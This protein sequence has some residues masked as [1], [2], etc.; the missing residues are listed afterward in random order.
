MYTTI[1]WGQDPPPSVTAAR[2]PGSPGEDGFGPLGPAL[3]G[4]VRRARG[5][6]VSRGAD[7]THHPARRGLLGWLADR[8][9]SCGTGDPFHAVLRI[10]SAAG[11][12]RP[13]PRAPHA[14]PAD[15]VVTPCRF[16]DT[17]HGGE[18]LVPAGRR[19]GGTRTGRA[20]KCG[21]AVP[22]AAASATAKAGGVHGRR[23]RGAVRIAAAKGATAVAA[24]ASR[25][26]QA[27]GR[28]HAGDPRGHR[29]LGVR[30]RARGRGAA[31]RRRPAFGQRSRRARLIAL[32]GREPP[33]LPVDA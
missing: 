23:D 1:P 19:G 25:A 26:P 3:A 33:G 32:H 31:G 20:T 12:R 22:E 15:L 21:S 2:S 16:G 9:P 7:A 30:S 11:P 5:R 24:A 27:A 28:A 18:P 14:P 29:C 10:R 13:A 17:P 8:G 4:Q 6:A